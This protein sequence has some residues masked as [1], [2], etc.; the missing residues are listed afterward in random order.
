MEIKKP[1]NTKE[2]VKP[3]VDEKRKRDEVI[4]QPNNNNSIFVDLTE[5]DSDDENDSSLTK[6]RQRTRSN[7]IITSKVCHI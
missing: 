6:K 3:R 2:S 4:L 7:T 1:S 5:M